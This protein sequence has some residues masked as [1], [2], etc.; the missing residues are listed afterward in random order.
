MT[1]L[2]II[3]SLA[4][5]FRL[6]YIYQDKSR[7]KLIRNWIR[8][9]YGT[10]P[11]KKNYNWKNI[12]YYWNEFS[13][14]IP[15]DEKIDEVTWNDLEMNEIFGRMN[16]CTSFLG[17]QVLYFTL[18]TMRK[19][20]TS[21]HILNKKMDYFSKN[22]KEREEIQYLLS[23]LGKE[24]DSYYFPRFINNMDAFRISDIWKYRIL[25]LVY[26]LSF[27]PAIIYK[28]PMLLVLSFCVLILNSIVY[29]IVKAKYEVILN[30][31]NDMINIINISKQ[32]SNMKR[33]SYESEFH[34]VQDKLELFK[35]IP[36]MFR[37][38]KRSKAAS[39][40]GQFE[41]IIIDYVIGSTLIDI[42]KYNR[43][44]EFL[45]NEKEKFMALYQ[46]IGEIDMAIAIT[47][48][49]N[50]LPFYCNPNFIDN[51]ELMMEQIYHPLIDDPI[52]NTITLNHNCI[53]T[54]SNASGKST[55]IK[56]IAVNVILAHSIYTCMAK[57]M[58][59]PRSWVITSMA[60]RDDLMS[61]ESYYI[62]EIKYL[63][64]IIQNL[65]EDRM[66]I[67]VI[68][69]I[70]RG[71]NTQERIAASTA[72]LRYLNNKNCIAIV[73]SH[74]IELTKI[75]NDCFDNYHFR[76]QIINKDIY[77]DYTIHEGA[78]T[79][80]NAIKLLEFVQFP[81]EIVNDARKQISII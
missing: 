33:L 3:S 75:L 72:I 21:S 53:I 73:A 26:I 69:E 39:M 30:S 7:T 59:L 4:L 8:D 71:T 77:F 20:E 11:E 38:M 6:D 27:L 22:E 67:C 51:H 76:E 13:K 19:N 74:D 41:T 17:E 25:Q 18:H 37:G 29:N 65:S 32:I 12:S 66:V 52:S 15:N 47:S 24:E 43:V 79:S 45:K 2:I 1:I 36:Q 56:A 46:V 68:D 58:I 80:K 64:R 28:N 23:R 16:G 35:K 63:N 54:G 40:S 55:F 34:E 31:L 14:E 57:E 50:S 61:G 42:L 48:F 62:K 49:R 44:M 70:L 81:E 78:S 5:I 60:V 10:K 9:H